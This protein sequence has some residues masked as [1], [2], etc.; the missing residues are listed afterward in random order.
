MQALLRDLVR[1]R[2]A[3]DGPAR[4]HV[5]NLLRQFPGESSQSPTAILP[6]P[7]TARQLEIL[8]L[9]AEGRSNRDIAA[10]LYIA[11]GTVKAHMHQIFGKLAARNRT[12]AVTAAR[13]LHLLP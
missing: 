7:L 2:I 3:V 13:E 4:Q 11:E 8:R 10:D 1:D 12:E 6:E 9:L 5:L